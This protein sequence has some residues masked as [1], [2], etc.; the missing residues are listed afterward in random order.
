MTERILFFAY[1]LLSVA[2]VAAE[3]VGASAFAGIT[4]ACLMPLLLAWLVV[5]L[6]RSRPGHPAARWL[7]VGLVFAWFGDLLLNGDG[8][9]VFKAGIVAFL[10]MQLC[11]IASFTRIPGPGLV[12]S[13]KLLALPYL[14]LWALLN[15]SLRGRV[16][17]LGPAVLVYSAVLIG[18]ALAALDLIGRVDRRMGW[19]V[20]VG[21]PIFVVSDSMIALTAFGPLP[22]SHAMD[23]AIMATYVVAQGLIVTGM[24]GALGVATASSSAP[25]SPAGMERGG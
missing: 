22:P 2:N 9:S 13:R 16:G 1:A 20:A 10:V 3:A 24:A 25:T 14:A 7:G 8:A 5:T 11:Y 18:M 19:R 17:A 23:A 12:R 21:A 4:K 6:R 15:G